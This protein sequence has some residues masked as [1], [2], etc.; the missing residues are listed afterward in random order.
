MNIFQL[1]ATMM[2]AVIGFKGGRVLSTL[3]AVELGA[4]PFSAGLLIATYAVFPLVFAVRGPD[5]HRPL[6]HAGTVSAQVA[7]CAAICC[8]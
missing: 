2:F 4:S 1:V 3:Y 6:R 7:A 5:R 8:T